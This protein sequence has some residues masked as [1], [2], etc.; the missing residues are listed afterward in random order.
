MIIPASVF[1]DRVGKNREVAGVHFPADTEAGKML[2]Q[3]LSERCWDLIEA[4]KINDPKQDEFARLVQDIRREW[5]VPASYELY[6]AGV[7]ERGSLVDTIVT[8]LKGI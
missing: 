7:T 1:A 8:K 5:N 3:D 4:A 6:A 2:A